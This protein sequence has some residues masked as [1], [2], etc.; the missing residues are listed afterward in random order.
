MARTAFPSLAAK[1][2][3]LG[4]RLHGLETEVSSIRAE[5]ADKMY[6]VTQRR[7]VSDRRVHH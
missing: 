2:D 5:M 7:K 1:V 4:H 3:H 6:I